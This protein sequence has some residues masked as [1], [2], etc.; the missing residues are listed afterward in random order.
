MCEDLRNH[1]RIL[2]AGN[3][4]NGAA[5]GLT[6][7]DIDVE[8]ALEA[9]CPGHG[10]VRLGWR[11]LLCGIRCA[12]VV[13]FTALGRRHERPM[14]AVGGEHTVEARQVH[15]RFEYQ[16]GQTGDEVQGLEDDVRGAVTVGRLELVAPAHPCA[17]DISDSIHVITHVAIGG[18]RQAFF[19][20]WRAG[21]VAAQ[22]LQLGTFI[23]LRLWLLSRSTSCPEMDV[24]GFTQFVTIARGCG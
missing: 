4:P 3:D 7:L 15:A 20:H 11:L 10:G 19:R 5:T 8:H 9:P 21:D 17:R 18:E 6:G 23:G 1:H 16:G 12:G 24:K 2:D 14:S 22:P 13:A